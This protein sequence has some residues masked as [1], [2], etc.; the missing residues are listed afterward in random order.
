MPKG[1]VSLGARVLCS[2][3]LCGCVSSEWEGALIKWE[4]V[5][6]VKPLYFLPHQIEAMSHQDYFPKLTLGKSWGFT[7]HSLM[8]SYI[9]NAV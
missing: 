5:N 8:V 1:V 7:S 3:T 9:E 6:L 2:D 4:Q